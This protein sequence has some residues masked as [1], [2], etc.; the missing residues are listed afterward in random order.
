MSEKVVKAALV[1]MVAGL[2][3]STPAQNIAKCSG[4]IYTRKQVTQPAR[5]TKPVDFNPIY[6]T[7]GNGLQAHVVVDAVLCRTGRVTDIKVVE[8]SPPQIREFVVSAFSL[9]S[10]KPAEMNWHTVSQRQT[11]E[12]SINESG[13][14]PIEATRASA[15]VVE[16]LDVMGNRR[17]TMQQIMSW[18]KTRPGENFNN[19]QIQKDLS[20]ILA[21]GYFNS[22]STRVFIE[23][24][25]RGGVRV[26][27]EVHE[28][29]LI[30]G[31]QFEGL[32]ESD[33]SRLIEELRKQNAGV[34][35][36]APLDLAKVKK[37]EQV[38]RQFFEA[39]GW[40]DVTTEALFDNVSATEVT[41]IFRVKAFRFGP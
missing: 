33:R 15:R 38:I 26:V 18:I 1:L 28:L 35:K 23:D 40:R 7:F 9:I 37:A 11:F 20:A 24:A 5:I 19:E 27:F 32:K 30:A 12:F 3:V 2:S 36:G 13:I 4:R 25:V 16:E 22:L 14:S 8:I 41:I 17:L 39:Q 10:F 21:T 31:V 34:Q 6:R 29:P